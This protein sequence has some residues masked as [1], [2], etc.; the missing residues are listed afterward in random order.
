MHQEMIRKERQEKEKQKQLEEQA[1]AENLFTD[2]IL[3]GDLQKSLRAFDKNDKVSYTLSMNPF[4]SLMSQ[5]IVVYVCFS[6]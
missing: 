1:A 2:D 6:H 4:G 3:D 5:L